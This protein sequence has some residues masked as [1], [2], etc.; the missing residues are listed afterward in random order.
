MDWID[1]DKHRYKSR[2]LVNA[3]MNLQVPYNAVNFLTS[4]EPAS[5][6]KRAMLHGVSELHNLLG[7]TG[8]LASTVITL[9]LQHDVSTDVMN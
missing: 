1:L 2:A 6:S 8:L 9:T 7:R 4:W 3:L 5:L